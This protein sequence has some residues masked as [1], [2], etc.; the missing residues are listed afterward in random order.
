MT[1][2]RS[3][4]LRY[5]PG[6]ITGASSI[7]M[8]MRLSENGGAGVEGAQA[9]SEQ[10]ERASVARVERSMRG[11]NRIVTD[12]RVTGVDPHKVCAVSW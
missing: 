11:L 4:W 10:T 8:A 2:V 6:R 7:V 12:E 3:H 5:E 1:S 9:V